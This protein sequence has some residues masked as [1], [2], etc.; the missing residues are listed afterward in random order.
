MKYLIII[1]LFAFGCK[2]KQSQ[3]TKEEYKSIDYLLNENTALDTVLFTIKKLD[4]FR[5][6]QHESSSKTEYDK[7][8]DSCRKQRNILK[9]YANEN[10]SNN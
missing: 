10:K 7:W 9:K 8:E 3:L 2:E 4:S 5:N 1:A 6:L